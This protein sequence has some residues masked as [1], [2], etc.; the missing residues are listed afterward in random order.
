MDFSERPIDHELFDLVS[1][2]VRDAWILAVRYL[3]DGWGRSC[4]IPQGMRGF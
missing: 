3:P 2:P 1:H 4:R